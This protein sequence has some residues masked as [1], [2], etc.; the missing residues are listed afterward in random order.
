VHD[1]AGIEE[2]VATLA[3]QPGGGLIAL[4]DAFNVAHA[5]MIIA[6]ATGQSLP[7]ISLGDFFPK[8]GALISYW[9]DPVEVHAQAASHIDRILRGTSP[10]ELPV[11]EPTKFS[12]VINLKTA[13][14]L[15]LTMPQSLLARANEVIE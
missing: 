15:G 10:A 4:P 8:A 5:D 11:Q 6:A 14:A 12:L 13:T 1:D 7:L 2:A 3:L 9:Y